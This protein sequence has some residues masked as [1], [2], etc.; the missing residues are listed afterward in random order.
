MELYVHI[1]KLKALGIAQTNKMVTNTQFHAIM[2]EAAMSVFVYL[3]MAVGHTSLLK[4]FF[5]M[6]ENFLRFQL[7]RKSITLLFYQ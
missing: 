3:S 7:A 5:A 4:T 2:R 6:I 1:F